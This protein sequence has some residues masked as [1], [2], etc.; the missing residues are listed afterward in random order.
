MQKIYISAWG[1]LPD[2]GIYCFQLKENGET[3]LLSK[4]PFYHAG[5]LAWNSDKSRL[6][7][8]G[9]LDE[10]GDF[11]GAFSVAEDGSLKQLNIRSSGGRSCCHLCV[12]P[13]DRFVYAANY[14]TGNF[15]E[16]AI[17]SDGSLSEAVRTIQH[18]G[19]GPHPERQLSAHA[20][21]CGFSPDGKFLLVVDLGMD[22]VMAYPYI[23]GRGIETDKVIRNAVTPGSGPRHL[24]FDRSGKIAYLIT[25][26][27]NTVQSLRYQEGHFEF[28]S[29]ISTLPCRISYPTKAAAVRLSADERFLLATNRGFDSVALIALDGAGGMVLTD[30]TLSGGN[31]P[32][33]LNFLA[34]D[35]FAAVG[36]EFS[37][38]VYFFNYNPENGRLT[39]NGHKL[40]LPRPLCFIE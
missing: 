40:E 18:E 4:A 29:E 39:P 2:G 31:S 28:I 15:S 12:S 26:L 10:R 36:N 5:Y 32:R 9:G 33:D 14:F 17:L 3:V 22:A 25:E 34:G 1:D 7:A 37:N 19:R 6:Y 8:T 38:S 11:V 21:F 16:Y 30:L 13:D 23:P 20:H 24:V 35:R 27:G